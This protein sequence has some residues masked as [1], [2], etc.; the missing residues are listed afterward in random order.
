MSDETQ[1]GPAE[2]GSAAGPQRNTGRQPASYEMTPL[3]EKTGNPDLFAFR[4]ELD[5]G[6]EK[7]A[8]EE[9]K[10][11]PNYLMIVLLAAAAACCV[12]LV[13]LMVPSLGKSKKV[14]ANY[15]DLGNE[16]FEPAGVGGR[17]IARW[18]EGAIYR[19]SLDPLELKDAAR[20][21]SLA[22][23]AQHPVSVV[24]RMKNAAGIAVCQKEIALAGASAQPQKTSGGDTVQLVSGGDGQIE[25]ITAEGPIACPLKV[26]Q[27][28]T[29]WDF[30][31][32][33]MPASG[34]LPKEGQAGKSR[35]GEQGSALQI[36]RLSGPIE[37]DDVIVADN[38]QRG[39]VETSAGRTFLVGT[40]G[41]RKRAP[42]WQVFPAAI[43]FRCDRNAV[44][45]LSRSNA[46]ST[47]Q[48]RLMK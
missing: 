5:P 33:G 43:H 15:V 4:T 11:S 8:S 9:K 16:R 30:Y 12:V 2:P 22:R 47:L 18:G 45:T 3:S 19:L 7:K 13:V 42:G 21:Q 26:Y 32:N 41:L 46:T 27:S 44:C 29:A 1:Q 48:A 10:S 40:A 38:T 35:A 25:E 24:I 39:T 34:A 36:Q 14:T 17:L 6:Q 31:F 23:N 28:L 37:G 20:F